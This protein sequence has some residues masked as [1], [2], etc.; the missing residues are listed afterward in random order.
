MP[1]IFTMMHACDYFD[2][3]CL[4]LRP[5]N[6]YLLVNFVFGNFALSLGSVIFMFVQN[7]KRRMKTSSP[8]KPEVII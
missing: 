8:I 6:V 4:C 1:N 2:C 3:R 7:T 5:F